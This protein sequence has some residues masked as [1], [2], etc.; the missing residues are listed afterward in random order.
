MGWWKLP[1]SSDEVMGDEAAD[2]AVELLAPLTERTPL[3]LLDELLDAL[4]A[5]LEL[6]PSALTARPA[7]I[8]ITVGAMPR[9]RSA[10]AREL[11]DSLLPG[12]RGLGETYQENFKR[13][14]T[15]R[16][17]LEAISF[18]LCSQ[19]QHYVRELEVTELDEELTLV[20]SA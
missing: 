12:L 8:R 14:P 1:G 13:P 6:E 16:E 7:A 4:E 5:A 3:P 9:Q 18:V 15:V 10:P 20:E 19:P 2:A 11:V 17:C